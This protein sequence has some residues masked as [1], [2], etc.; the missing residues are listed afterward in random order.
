M[1]Y[2]LYDQDGILC[3]PWLQS[4]IFTISSIDNIDHIQSSNTAKTRCLWYIIYSFSALWQAIG[5]GS[6]DDAMK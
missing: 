1:L 2:N 3:P 5:N 6:V 4:C